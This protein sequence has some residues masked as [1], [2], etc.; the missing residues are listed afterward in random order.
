[1]NIGFDAKRAFLNFTGLGNYSRFVIQA[2]QQNYADDH[3]FLFTPRLKKHPETD[4]LLN[5]NTTIVTPSGITKKVS[6][7]WRLMLG[8]FSS[9]PK[10]LAVFHGLSAE[11]PF[12]LPDSVAKVVTVHD[13]IFLRFPQFYNPIDVSIYKAKVKSACT[14]ADKIVAISQQTADDIVDYLNIDRSKIEIIYQGCHENFK[15]TVSADEVFTVKQK[16][17]LPNE[18]ILNVGTIEERKNLG[19]LVKSLARLPETLR[20]PLVVLGRFTPYTKQVMDE[21]RR[22]NVLN[23]IIFLHNASFADFPAIYKGAKIFVYPSLFEGFGIPLVEAIEVGVPVIT[24]TGSCFHEAAGP[25]AKY[26]NPLNADELSAAL[27]EILE[28][29]QLQQ[30]M[31]AESKAYITK[32]TPE[33]IAHAFHRLYSDLAK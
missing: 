8:G 21:A 20:I 1:M 3:Y 6:G 15:R 11:L 24:S 10:T 33:K 27:T 32:F 13:L 23:A 18:Y 4:S 29:D 28:S 14:R 25:G 5:Q 30:T 16:Y 26:I 19:V 17:K 2:L 22:L 7:A 12:L 9:I 31:V